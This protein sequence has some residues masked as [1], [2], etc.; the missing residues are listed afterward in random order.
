MSRP[1]ASVDTPAMT[2]LTARA[3]AETPSC[4]CVGLIP[5]R[6]PRFDRDNSSEWFPAELPRCDPRLAQVCWGRADRDLRLAL[7]RVTRF[8]LLLLG[9]VVAVAA[10]IGYAAAGTPGL[11]TGVVGALLGAALVILF[12]ALM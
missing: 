8:L 10:A 6:P 2:T 3:S 12:S 1:G 4:P 9:V 5:L 7:S 11:L